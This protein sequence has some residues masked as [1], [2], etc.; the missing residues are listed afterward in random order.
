MYTTCGFCSGSLGGDGA[1]S[2]LGVGKR[3]AYDA[4]KSR[5][6]VICRRCGRWNLTPI[7]NRIETIE[8]LER[9]AATGR[10]AATS[11]QVSLIRAAAYDIVRVGQPRR[12]ELATWRYGERLKARERE[13][14]KVLVPTIVVFVG[15]TLAFN[16]ALGG[17]FG[18]MIGQI[19]QMA[20][21]VYTGIVG[22]R[23][24]AI[25]PPICAA[26]GKVMVLRSKHVRH[27]RI[28]ETTHHDL[29]LLLSCPD[30]RREG[31]LLEGADAEVALRSGL[32][33]VNLKKARKLRKKAPEA[34]SF[35]D[36][37]GGPEAF[38]RNSA[39]MELTVNKLESTQALALEM[40][41][42]EQAELRELERQWRQAEEIAEI[43]DDLTIGPAVEE[44]FR[45]LKEGDQPF[46]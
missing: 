38:I 32:T 13:R 42:D 26:C 5:A 14:M 9:I 28:T 27:A 46:G 43:A 29:A 39:R 16:A 12:V 45:R 6:W 33:Y 35:V 20:D 11:D 44:E 1:S 23:K 7:D 31:A 36:R 30:C 19:P 18:Y 25:E 17:S 22:R 4:W 10:V 37:Q 8:A 2:G 21:G 24:V 34:A 40:A 15:V 41:V 3:F